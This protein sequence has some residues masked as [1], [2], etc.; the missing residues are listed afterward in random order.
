MVPIKIAFELLASAV[1]ETK[2]TAYCNP[3]LPLKGE[4]MPPFLK[5]PH[6]SEA[7]PRDLWARP[8]KNV[9]FLGIST[10]EA[11]FK[12]LNKWGNQKAYPA[13]MPV[14]HLRDQHGKIT[15]WRK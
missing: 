10:K 6:T 3:L 5:T 9:L 2:H 7:G 11:P 15:L 14:N 1:Q 12:I 8:D 4:C 13:M